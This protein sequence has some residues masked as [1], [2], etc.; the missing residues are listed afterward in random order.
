MGEGGRTWQEAAHGVWDC[1]AAGARR[2]LQLAGHSIHGSPRR[3]YVT[4]GVLGPRACA[5]VCSWHV[6]LM[7]AQSRTS[8]WGWTR[9]VRA[10]DEW[11]AACNLVRLEAWSWRTGW[12]GA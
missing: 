8:Y 6:Q 10:V 7:T 9:T 5:G 2:G 4:P 12:A 3:A 1:V 11:H